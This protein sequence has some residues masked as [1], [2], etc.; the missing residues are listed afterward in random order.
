[1]QR[2]NASDGPRGRFVGIGILFFAGVLLVSVNLREAGKIGKMV[3]I[4][5]DIPAADWEL[6]HSSNPKHDIGCIPFDQ[7]CHILYRTWRTAAPV[8]VD[9]VAA[10]TGYDM[11]VGKIYRPDCA[12]GYADAVAIRLCVDGADVELSMRD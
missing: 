3:A 8:S 11:E 9:E 2:G 12:D 1:M 10:S 6:T 5:D 7:S 4:A